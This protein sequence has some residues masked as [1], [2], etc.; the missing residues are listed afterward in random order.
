MTCPGTCLC[1]RCARLL[2]CVDCIYFAWSRGTGCGEG[3]TRECRYFEEAERIAGR[4]EGGER[5]DGDEGK[6][7]DG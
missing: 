5:S 4:R 2:P 3:G 1:A 6:A 7:A